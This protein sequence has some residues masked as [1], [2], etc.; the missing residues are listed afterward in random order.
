MTITTKDDM[1]DPQILIEAVRGKLKHRTAFM[2]S[3]LASSGAVLISGS[4]PEG[5]QGAVGKTITVPYFGTIGKFV[6]NPDGSSVTPTNLG[7]TS[8]T[9]TL[10]RDSLAI[11]ISAW[12]QGV[13]AV[14]SALGDPYDEGAAQAMQAAEN[15]MDEAIVSAFGAT[16]MARDIYGATSGTAGYLSHRQMVRSKVLWGDEQEDIVAAVTHSQAEADLAELVDANGRPLLVESF[17]EGGSVK[18]F[19]GMPLIV[20]DRVPLTGSTMGTVVS[21]GTTPPVVS[22]AG[23]PLGPWDLQIDCVTGGLSDG[24]ATF[25]FSVDGGSHW[26]ATYAI[27]SGGG[28]F[29]LNDSYQAAAADID[30]A[31]TVDSM[32]GRNGLT[33]ITATFANGTYNADNLYVSTANLKVSTL[34]C[35]RGAGAFWYNAQRL[36]AKTDTD[37]LADTDLLAMHLYRAA[38]LYRRR[39]GG[40]RPGVVALKHNVKNYVG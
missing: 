39:R 3:L 25:R 33:G 4:M 20:S 17:T 24:T 32:V 19:N 8:E 1:L 30:G 38:H 9:S 35:Q 18:R 22:L 21:T 16:P 2:G 10:A 15:A 6:N 28:A 29:V 31:Q 27:P 37:I 40:S 36:G 13:G 34:L 7:Q 12:A 23:E 11:E 5:G 26:S 14:N